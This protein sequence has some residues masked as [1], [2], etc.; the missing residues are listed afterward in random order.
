MTDFT[1]TDQATGNAVTGPVDTISVTG[2]TIS[3][4]GFSGGT[5][6]TTNDGT[7]V[8]I[9][10]ANTTTTAQGAFFG[11][12]TAASAPDEVGGLVLQQGDDGI[13]AGGFVAD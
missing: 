10:G 13:L 2:M 11:Y 9:T 7:A 12:D 1:V 6:A 3:G 5:V 4:N 8:N